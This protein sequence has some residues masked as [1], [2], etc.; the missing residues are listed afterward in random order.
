DIVLRTW[1]WF[2]LEGIA[3][4]VFTTQTP[5][6]STDDSA[7]KITLSV[8]SA[9]AGTVSLVATATDTGGFVTRVDFTMDG[10][11]LA[12]LM[13]EPFA[14]SA[15]VAPGNHVFSAVAHD[16]SGAT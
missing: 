12:T 3:F 7:L 5:P 11:P 1:P 4:Y 2:Q 13:S 9:G 15:S 16:T 8:Q 6:G 10:A 14:L